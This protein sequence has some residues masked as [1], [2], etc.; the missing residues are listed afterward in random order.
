MVPAGL[1]GLQDLI[2]VS[3]VL[4]SPKKA[5]QEGAGSQWHIWC[6]CPQPRSSPECP[7]SLPHVGVAVTSPPLL[8]ETNG[9]QELLPPSHVYY[10]YYLCADLTPCNDLIC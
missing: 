3:R 6:H 8:A 7:L 9:K 4:V 2:G 1:W 5:P 10:S